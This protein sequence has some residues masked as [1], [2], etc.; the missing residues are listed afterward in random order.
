MHYLELPGIIT[1]LP[2]WYDQS[3]KAY[4]IVTIGITR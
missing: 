4:K 3:M 2:P 1:E